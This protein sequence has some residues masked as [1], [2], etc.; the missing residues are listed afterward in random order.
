MIFTATQLY[1][2]PV[3][4]IRELIQELP[5]L[6]PFV[7]LA[8]GCVVIESWIYKKDKSFSKNGWFSGAAFFLLIINVAWSSWV[9]STPI[10]N[11]IAEQETAISI[12]VTICSFL[13]IAY[14]IIFIAILAGTF[15]VLKELSGSGYGY[16]LLRLSPAIFLVVFAIISFIHGNSAVGENGLIDLIINM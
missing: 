14:A 11:L 6:M 8:L 16:A 3:I 9:S 4:A 13:I 10:E 7:L 15:R 12:T 1:P 5:F 2:T